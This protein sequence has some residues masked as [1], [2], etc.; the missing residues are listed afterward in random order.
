M[1]EAEAIRQLAE[2][3]RQLAA[4][5]QAA[6]ARADALERMVRELC[7]ANHALTLAVATLLGEEMGGPAPA[8]RDPHATLDD[9]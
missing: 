8:E 1:A 5:A 6:L 3:A 7:E 9:D 4:T 2:T